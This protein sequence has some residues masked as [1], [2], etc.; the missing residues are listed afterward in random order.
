MVKYLNFHNSF[1]AFKEDTGTHPGTIAFNPTF[2]SFYIIRTGFTLGELVILVRV[3]RLFRLKQI[4][5]VL[6][7]CL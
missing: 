4:F 5:W 3:F 1:F 7:V 6:R 2:G